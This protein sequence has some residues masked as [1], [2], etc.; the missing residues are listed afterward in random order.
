MSLAAIYL[1]ILNNEQCYAV[2]NIAAVP[3]DFIQLIA[4]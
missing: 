2:K 1:D 4:N 3:V